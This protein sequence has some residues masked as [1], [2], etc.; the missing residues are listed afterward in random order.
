VKGRVNLNEDASHETKALE[1][2]A[3]SN[4]IALSGL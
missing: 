3:F 4:A 2:F 1:K